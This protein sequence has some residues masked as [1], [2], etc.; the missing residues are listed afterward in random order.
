MARVGIHP[1]PRTEEWELSI[2]GGLGCSLDLFMDEVTLPTSGTGM[3]RVLS[4]A[5]KKPN[6]IGSAPAIASITTIPRDLEHSQRAPECPQL[7][8]KPLLSWN[9]SQFLPVKVFILLAE[10]CPAA[11]GAPR[12]RNPLCCHQQHT[13]I[14]AP[15][16]SLPLLQWNINPCLG[17]AEQRLSRS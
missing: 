8:L 1:L 14:S 13:E 7:P 10:P 2:W 15:S 17:R 5:Y 3:G 16:I 6:W 11:Q 4:L 12:Q 9:L